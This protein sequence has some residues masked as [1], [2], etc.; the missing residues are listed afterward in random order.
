MHRERNSFLYENVLGYARL[1][2]GNL[3]RIPERL[4]MSDAAEVAD[5]SSKLNDYVFDAIRIEYG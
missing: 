1:V 3:K 4:V 2:W 5:P